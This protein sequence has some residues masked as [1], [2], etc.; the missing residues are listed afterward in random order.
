MVEQMMV[1]WS[2]A[3]AARRKKRMVRGAKGSSLLHEE[4]Q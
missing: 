2:S 3:L 4:P 1:G